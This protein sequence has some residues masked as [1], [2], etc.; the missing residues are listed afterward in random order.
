MRRVA[1]KKISKVVFNNFEEVKEMLTN[2]MKELAYDLTK[3]QAY[4][5]CKKVYHIEK[6]KFFSEFK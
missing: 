1:S 4:Q 6:Y 5:W 3:K 2:Y